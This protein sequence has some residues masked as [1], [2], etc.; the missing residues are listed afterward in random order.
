MTRPD[1]ISVEQV[2]TALRSLYHCDTESDLQ[3]AVLESLA[4]GLRPV[5]DK[6]RWRP[7]SI[8]ILMALLV[9][10]LAGIFLYFSIGAHS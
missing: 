1:Y 5:D 7:S 9:S 4:D 6:G 3:K 10:A 8:L 2:R